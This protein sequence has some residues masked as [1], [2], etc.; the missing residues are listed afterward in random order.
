MRR[1][2]LLLFAF[3]SACSAAKAD[4]SPMPRERPRIELR[5]VK[6]NFATIIGAYVRDNDIGVQVAPG[7]AEDGKMRWLPIEDWAPSSTPLPRSIHSSDVGLWLD[8]A[9][10]IGFA[11]TPKTVL[12]MFVWQQQSSGYAVW[13]LRKIGIHT[14]DVSQEAM[15]AGVGPQ[16]C[17]RLTDAERDAR[18]K[19]LGAWSFY[20]RWL[21][22]RFEEY[23]PTET[24][25]ET[26]VTPSFPVILPIP[27]AGCEMC[28]QG[29][30]SHC[31]GNPAR[32]YQ[33]SGAKSGCCV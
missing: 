13:Q 25:A 33:P 12:P 17:V 1:R 7:R 5:T 28:M 26:S 24:D 11:L 20:E 6:Q 2:V 8:G 14:P 27:V 23:T 30:P 16:W 29:S 9:C 10:T 3:G 4:P 31:G 18:I 21:P 19:G 32:C 22:E 15:F